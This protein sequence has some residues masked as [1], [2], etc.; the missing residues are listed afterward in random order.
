MLMTNIQTKNKK[1]VFAL[2]PLITISSVVSLGLWL[3]LR[4]GDISDVSLLGNYFALSLSVTPL[5]AGC[6]GFRI[7]QGWGGMK[8]LLGKAILA[9]SAGLV[10]W[11]L[12]NFTW[13]YY[14]LVQHVAAPYPSLADVGYGSGVLFWILSTIYIGRAVG[15]P[16]LIKKSPK[17]K[18]IAATFALISI[19]LSYYLLITVARG[20]DLGFQTTDLLKV[21][22]DLYYPL[23]DVCS[24]LIILSVVIVS[25]RYIGGLLRQPVLL[26]LFGVLASYIFDL[27]FSYATTK[28]TYSNGQFTDVFL[29]VGTVALSF[30]IAMFGTRAVNLEGK[31]RE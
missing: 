14:N 27:T 8:S 2:L 1:Q 25:G 20:G 3:Y 19:V 12:G 4:V 31:I 11:S 9:L 16:L 10:L 23:T 6:F 15:V 17:L 26:I 28:E 24:L 18:W 7:A 29:L 13:A 21:F 30:S 5:L 22:F